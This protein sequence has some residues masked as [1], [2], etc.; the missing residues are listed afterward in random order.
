MKEY[1]VYVSYDAGG[2]DQYTILARSEEEAYDK[3]YLDIG[4]DPGE[5]FIEEK[6]DDSV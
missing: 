5:V 3:V 1:Y 2:E 4:Y 6:T